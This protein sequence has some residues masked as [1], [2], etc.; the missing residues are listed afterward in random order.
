MSS[1]LNGWLTETMRHLLFNSYDNR[2]SI[3]SYSKNGYHT[4]AAT[5]R[6]WF[7]IEVTETSSSCCSTL[8]T[9]DRA[10]FPLEMTETML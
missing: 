1:K 4:L 5:D 3:V 6:A 9:K 2:R 7:P 8:I 10:R